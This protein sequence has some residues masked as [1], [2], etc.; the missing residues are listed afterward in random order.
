MVNHPS[1]PGP[2]GGHVY[3][4]KGVYEPP[5]RTGTLPTTAAQIPLSVVSMSM[6]VAPTTPPG[7]MTRIRR[8]VSPRFSKPS[9]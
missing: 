5:Q 4:P 2:C 6:S 8:T 3:F 9:R 7:M 1:A